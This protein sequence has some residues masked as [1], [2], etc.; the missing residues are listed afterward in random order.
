MLIIYLG[1]CR[2]FLYFI[3]LFFTLWVTH[4]LWDLVSSQ[5]FGLGVIVRIIVGAEVVD[6]VVDSGVFDDVAVVV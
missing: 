3:S 4:L 6:I 1:Y 5:Q 2:F